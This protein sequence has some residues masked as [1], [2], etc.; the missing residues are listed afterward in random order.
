VASAAAT[1]EVLQLA[2]QAAKEAM[3]MALQ[4]EQAPAPEP[5]SEPKPKPAAKPA[6]KSEPE[7]EPES[8]SAPKPDFKKTLSSFSKDFVTSMLPPLVPKTSKGMTRE[9]I[10][11]KLKDSSWEGFGVASQNVTVDEH[12]Q[13]GFTLSKAKLY[14]GDFFKSG[15]RKAYTDMFG[16]VNVSYRV[17]ESNGK[18]YLN[19]FVKPWVQKAAASVPQPQP[20]PQSQPK[21]EQAKQDGTNDEQ[22]TPEQAAP[23]QVIPEQAAPEQAAPEQAVP[24]QVASE[25]VADVEADSRPSSPSPA[26]SKTIEPVKPVKGKKGKKGKGVNEDTADIFATNS[27]DNSLTLALFQSQCDDV[28]DGEVGT[29]PLAAPASTAEFKPEPKPDKKPLKKGS[30]L[31]FLSAA[32]AGTK[33]AAKLPSKKVGGN[34]SNTTDLSDL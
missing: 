34:I 13:D 17:V 27:E 29:T 31:N 7:S 9:Q 16:R 8:E 6:A 10:T 28:P 4:A 23:E 25:Q 20:Q 21:P 18:K 12:V 19:V 11:E 2:L 5:K 14:N 33:A 22:V 15:I 26:P 1:L 30:T 24:E 32:T 3:A